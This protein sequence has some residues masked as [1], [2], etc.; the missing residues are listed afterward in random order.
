MSTSF[1]LI[2]AFYLVGFAALH[3]LLAG[4]WLKRRA[5]RAFGQR[6]M[7]WYRLVYSIL[8]AVT[9]FPLLYLLYLFPGE[10][11]Y[12]VPSP[13]RWIMIFGQVLAALALGKTLL[14]SGPLRFL[15]IRPDDG[16]GEGEGELI[17][18]GI[19]CR[20]RNPLFLFALIFFWLTPVMTDN[21]LVLYLL[22]TIYF[23]LGSIHEERMLAEKFGDPYRDY[24]R[25]VPRIVPRLRCSFPETKGEGRRG[26]PPGP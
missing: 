9:L 21:L 8:T 18:R 22:A 26:Q 14:E 17:I 25:R 7:R 11:L 13:W 3:S 5:R 16:E 6:A 24:Q 2:L 20:V 12:L 19:Y 1:N 15:G 4:L 23:Y 10:V